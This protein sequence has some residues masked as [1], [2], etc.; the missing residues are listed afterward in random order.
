[1]PL[2]KGG[3]VQVAEKAVRQLFKASGH[4]I[5]SGSKRPNQHVGEMI[6]YAGTTAAGL[7]KMRASSLA[8]N[9][10]EGLD[11]ALTRTKNIA[12]E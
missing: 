1:M 10:K 6:E 3:S 8:A 12:T 7:E 9:I 5:A 11:A 4:I 2:R